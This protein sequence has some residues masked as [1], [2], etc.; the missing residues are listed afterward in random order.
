MLVT[1][2][3]VGELSAINAVAGAYAERV[4]IV[5]IT[6][7]P[8]RR[9]RERGLIVHHTLAHGADY[10]VFTRMHASVTAAQTVLAADNAGAEI[11]RVLQACI[12]GSLPVYIN[13]PED[14][15]TE[16][17]RGPP[18]A[19][20]ASLA[21]SDLDALSQAVRLIADW[22]NSAARLVILAD[23]GVQRARAHNEL[24]A[25]VE[26][27]D[28]PCATLGMGRTALDE[29]H[30]NHIGVYQGDRSWPRSV[31]D[32]VE[33]ADCVLAVGTNQTD[34]TTG[35]FTAHLD[36]RLMVDIKLN[37][38]KVKKA[39][40]ED[41]RSVDVLRALAGV[42]QR[43]EGAHNAYWPRRS[44]HDG[45]LVP[46]PALPG[47]RLTSD[48]FLAALQALLRPGDVLL[49]ETCTLTFGSLPMRIPSG[50][51]F[52][53]QALWGSIG[54]AGP[55]AGGAARAVAHDPSRRVILVTGDGSLQMSVQHLGTMLADG[56]AP[57]IFVINNDG[58]LIE[59]LLCKRTGARY[60]D[61]PRWRYA[62][63]PS[64]LGGD[65]TRV[66]VHVV[67]TADALAPAMAAAAEAQAEGKLVWVEL[68]T[69][70]LDVPQGARWL[71]EGL[72][73]VRP[74]TRH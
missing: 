10:D 34:W 51:E 16:R 63:L 48:A 4:P 14:V 19:Q 7:S 24:L 3:G 18:P 39:R 58:Y 44:R 31:Q 57:I 37:V 61:I 11:E 22:A 13:V 20:L 6:S 50:V 36:E 45:I 29:W 69:P 26:A 62:Q 66:A 60:N 42:L 32:V 73:T 74:A 33:A 46:P 5:V 9:V 56:L 47:A 72:Q 68:R 52:I 41:V 30:A 59:T 8:S 38:T 28:A 12:R 43:R 54:M 2:Y 17:V 49:L 27:T 35:S 23:I 67:D 55:A 1:T 71:T 40:F 25:L 21:E 70:P 64:A 65:E 15:A 53:T